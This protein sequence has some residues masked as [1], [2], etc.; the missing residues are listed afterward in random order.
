M[1]ACVAALATA[2]G[3]APSEAELRLWYTDPKVVKHELLQAWLKVPRQQVPQAIVADFLS[4]TL[5]G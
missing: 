2:R 1:T 5:S 3:K 4:C